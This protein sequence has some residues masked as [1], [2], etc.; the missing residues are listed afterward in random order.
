MTA[1]SDS[2][3]RAPAA[4]GER[5]TR[6]TSAD[7]VGSADAQGADGGRGHGHRILA[8]IVILGV[9]LRIAA[10]G[11]LGTHGDSLYEF[12][13]I[14][15]NLTHGRGYS[16]FSDTANRPVQI[17]QSHTGRPLPS[18]FMPPGYTILVAGAQGIEHSDKGATRLLQI[19]NVAMGA[20]TILLAY[21][22]AARLFG[23][24][25]GLWSALCVSVYPV[26][27]Y[28]A[29]QPSASNAYLPV[30]L[31]TLYLIV[32]SRRDASRGFAAAAGLGIGVACLFRAEALVLVPAF[33]AWLGWS[34]WRGVV[35][36]APRVKPVAIVLVAFLVPAVGVPGTWLLRNSLVFGQFTPTITTTGGFNLWIGNHAGATG[37]QKQFAPPSGS[38]EHELNRLPGSAKYEDQRDAKFL[39][40]TLHYIGHHPGATVVRDLK[41]LGMT[42]TLDVYDHR[43]RNV[44]YVGSWLVLLALGLAGMWRKPGEYVERAL[45]YGFLAYALAVPTLFFTLARYKLSVELVLL[46]F[47]GVGLAGVEH[48]V[49][50][51]LAQA[52]DQTMASRSA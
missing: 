8:G 19:F 4:G 32:R 27:L 51:S 52:R 7:K 36:Q 6:P 26:L 44:L 22:L 50:S 47:A 3:R 24:R 41:K 42:L 1:S 23:R 48:R 49:R 37:S 15:D 17:D 14:G 35:R 9:V 39:S 34:V 16:Y 29:T 11:A 31:A 30:D 43:S 40:A 12:G 33:A 5:N 45:L 25:P 10:I 13:V 18:A 21:L 2:P 38:L 46:L 28:Q 20:V